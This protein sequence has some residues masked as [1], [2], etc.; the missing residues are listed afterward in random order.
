MAQTT[1]PDVVAPVRNVASFPQEE[2]FVLWRQRLLLAALLL[3]AGFATFLIRHMFQIR[4]G[5]ELVSAAERFFFWTYAAV[6]AIFGLF[7]VLLSS[8]SPSSYFR[9]CTAEFVLFGFPTALFLVSQYFVTLRTCDTWGVFIFSG[10][11]WLLLI[12]TY[13]MF[14]PSTPPRAA[15]VIGA[16]A[17]APILLVLGMSLAH[18][19]VAAA[20]TADALSGLLIVL[21]VAV[22]GGI[23][24]V[25]KI[26]VLR[27]EALQAMR[28]GHYRLKEP[29]GSGGMGVVYLAEHE[30]L[31]RPCVIKLIRRDKVG[32]EKILARFQRE[33]QATARLSHWNTVEILDY[34]RTEDGTLYYVMEYL[35]GM[36][37]AEM[38]E[39]YGPLPPER[40]I[41]LLLQV[42][43]ALREAHNSGLVH[44]DIKP[45]NIF[46]SQR[47]GV[48][49]VV[50]ILDFGLVKPIADDQ[51]VHLTVDGMLAGTP[52]FMS[53]EQATGDTSGDPRSDIYSL[54]A[55]TYFVL[56]GQPP[57]RGDNVL[58]LVIAHSNETP[59]PPSRH[60]SK[61]PGDLE[62]I[63]LK[64]L[65]KDRSERFQ[66][67]SQLQSAL[68]QCETAGRWSRE[69]A[70]EWW[71]S[72][73][74]DA[75]AKTIGE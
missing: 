27:R 47:G 75:S 17:A 63:V 55:S 20:L 13:A 61:I 23:I 67:V 3:F 68:A 14:I 6:T 37:L 18:P 59:V 72:R 1:L 44:R 29:I 35:P 4:F 41:Y 8:R 62:Q 16:I 25:H 40:G 9:L 31:K 64:C 5:V 42:C 22:V 38:V 39:R 52:L 34:G 26:T 33:V 53:P 66:T 32:D 10:V 43:D 46:I 58:K 74:P 56:T 48:D 2:I 54:G 28:L 60:N 15:V 57:F 71:Q 21:L 24:G 70:A 30:M 45:A 65:A 36:S 49:D 11:P 12:F 51:P 69:K 19:K 50:K 7:G 73:A